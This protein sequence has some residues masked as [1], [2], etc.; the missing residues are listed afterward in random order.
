MKKISFVIDSL[1]IGGA[2]KVL[3]EFANALSDFFEVS[4]ISIYDGPLSS[5]LNEKVSLQIITRKNEKKSLLCRLY[6]VV[7][8]ELFIA[9]P[10]FFI[11]REYVSNAVVIAFLENQAIDIVKNVHREC[12]KIAWVHTNVKMQNKKFKHKPQVYECFPKIVFSSISA[13]DNFN[14]EYGESL[15]LKQKVIYNGLDFDAI[16]IMSMENHKQQFNC[17]DYSVSVGRLCD[18][19]NY[20]NLIENLYVAYNSGYRLNHYII[21]DGPD[22]K[23]IEDRINE[24]GLQKRIH[25]LGAL[26]NPYPYI[27]DAKLFIHNAKWEG[28]GLAVVEAVILNTMPIVRSNGATNEVVSLLGTGLLFESDVELVRFIIEHQD[29]SY[30]NCLDNVKLL[31]YSTMVNELKEFIDD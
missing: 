25:L 20:I 10:D 9:F 31:S 23:I 6:N 5:K 24:L 17:L 22:R 29:S 28:F 1:E 13:R 16:F 15:D 30:S 21:G 18:A 11:S 19:K 12:E 3:V 2:E 4:I 8:R 27:K 7:K 26:D 14:L